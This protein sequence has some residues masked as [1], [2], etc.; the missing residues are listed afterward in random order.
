MSFFQYYIFW[1]R[2]D[3][4]FWFRAYICRSFPLILGETFGYTCIIFGWG[5]FIACVR[6]SCVFF[7]ACSAIVLHKITK[8]PHLK[9]SCDHRLHSFIFV[10]KNIFY[11][12]NLL[13]RSLLFAWKC[14]QKVEY[15]FSNK[16]LI[17]FL[18]FQCTLNDYIS[19]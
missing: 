18:L 2:L 12:C 8:W 7:I 15:K 4:E 3:I 11:C 10:L 16:G 6:N 19:L 14:F 17:V 5:I 1:P 13:E 9:R